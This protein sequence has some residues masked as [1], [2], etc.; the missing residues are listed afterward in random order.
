MQG[1]KAHTERER[2]TCHTRNKEG[3][4]ARNEK[5]RRTRNRQREEK[6]E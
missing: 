1:C 2:E 5:E 4:K 3:R 6:K